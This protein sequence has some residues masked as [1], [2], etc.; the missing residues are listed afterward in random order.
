RAVRLCRRPLFI[1]T[2]RSV[3]KR[4]FDAFSG[5]R[6]LH[7]DR[8]IGQNGFV[9]R[10]DLKGAD[11]RIDGSLRIAGLQGSHT[12]IDESVNIIRVSAEQRLEQH[13]GFNVVSALQEA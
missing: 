6:L 1:G 13:E 10:I 5:G 11:V 2:S 8:K 3:S 4:Y 9:R 12:Q 7:E